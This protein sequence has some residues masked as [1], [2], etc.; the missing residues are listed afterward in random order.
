MHMDIK[1][2][3]HFVL[4]EPIKIPTPAD[5]IE[6]ITD[7]AFYMRIGRVLKAGPGRAMPGS[8]ERQPMDVKEGDYVLYP[9]GTKE[10]CSMSVE[11]SDLSLLLDADD[12][13]RKALLFEA[14]DL[15]GVPDQQEL[16]RRIDS[17][18][19]IQVGKPK[20]VLAQ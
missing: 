8:S 10:R 18:K 3:G 6:K 4:I 11:G 16:E 1:L 7:S 13:L 12:P 2:T 20:L 15:I 9:Q 14:Q 19:V 5:T 17:A